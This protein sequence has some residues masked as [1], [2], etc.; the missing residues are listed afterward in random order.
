MRLAAFELAEY[1]DVSVI[2][3]TDA[4]F[5]DIEGN[6][7][8]FGHIRIQMTNGL[9]IGGSGGA[10]PRAPVTV[11]SGGVRCRVR[12]PYVRKSRR[13]RTVGEAEPSMCLA[14]DA[15]TG[16]SATARA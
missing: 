9:R 13:G 12:M 4:V 10:R 11:V 1:A 6:D 2:Y 16:V 14:N 15:I 3:T 8:D 5:A 7:E